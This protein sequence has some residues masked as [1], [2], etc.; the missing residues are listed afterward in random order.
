MLVISNY[1]T[2]ILSFFNILC[3][4]PDNRGI[5]PL[6]QLVMSNHIQKDE[7]LYIMSEDLLIKYCSPTL[8]GLKT[9]SMF[10]VE[11]DTHKEMVAAFKK[12]NALL[13]KKGLR[14]IPLRK[15]TGRYLFYVF[16]PE[17]LAKELNCPEAQEILCSNGYPEGNVSKCL[18]CLMKRLA[19]QVDFPHEIGL[20]LGYPPYDVKEFMLNKS[21][22]KKIGYWK[23]YGDS[24][25]AEKT[26]TK[27]D[28]CKRIYLSEYSKGKSLDQL[29][30]SEPGKYNN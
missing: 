20:F 18:A 9:G 13:V 11:F 19:S 29:I 21:I 26:F 30:V 25:A 22:P 12:F 8:A 10:P 1:Y 17:R 4:A 24:E 6:S 15:K 7:V 14:A 16:R 23:V 5:L 28:K 27:Y 2:I 3:F